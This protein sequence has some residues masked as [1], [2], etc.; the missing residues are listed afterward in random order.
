MGPF[1]CF[2]S[3][4]TLTAY[5][6]WE[7]HMSGPLPGSQVQSWASFLILLFLHIPPIIHKHFHWLYFHPKTDSCCYIFNT[8]YYCSEIADGPNI[9]K[10]RFLV[11][12]MIGLMMWHTWAKTTQKTGARH[13]PSKTAYHISGESLRSSQNLLCF[14]FFHVHSNQDRSRKKTLLK[15]GIEGIYFNKIKIIYDKI[16]ADIILNGEKPKVFPLKWGRRQEPALLSLLF[17]TG[18]EVLSIELSI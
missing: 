17:N 14:L 18:L 8:L 16:T 15:V 7:N 1:I 4:S 5:Q 9:S 10:I 13:M 2:L 6:H 3:P 11:L 12:L